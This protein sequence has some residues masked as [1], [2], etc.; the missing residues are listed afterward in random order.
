MQ[1][2]RDY[3]RND[4]LRRA[5]DDLAEQ[6]FGFRFERW[7]KDGYF[8]GD[9]MP[10]SCEQDGRILANVSANRMRFRQNGRDRLYIQLGTVMTDPA[11]RRQGLAASLMK[12]VLEEYE[13]RCDG[14]YLFGDLSALGFYKKLGFSMGLQYRYTLREEVRQQLRPLFPARPEAVFQRIAPEDSPA[15]QRYREAVRQSAV[16]SALEQVNKYGLQMFYT[17]GGQNVFFCREL[18]C[19]AV[20]EPQGQELCLKSIICREKLP[21]E[22]ILQRIPLPFDQLTLGFAPCGE[23]AALFTASPFDGGEDY[24]F[25][26]RG[27]QLKSIEEE[28][29]YF[30]EL[31]HA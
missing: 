9:Y 1:L 24:R 13:G 11:F 22:Q 7:V 29:L 14:I 17:A 12:T 21:L 27:E 20:M 3:M 19:Y 23:D 6:T 16:Q 25:F 4:P 10:F 18:D 5:L 31:S 2:I 30:P 8:E 15:I 26:F 28:R